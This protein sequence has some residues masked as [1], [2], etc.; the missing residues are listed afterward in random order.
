VAKKKGG[1]PPAY[2]AAGV[3]VMVLL[4]FNG[5]NYF[6][7]GGQTSS[8]RTSSASQTSTQSTSQTPTSTTTTSTASTV[9]GY[10]P[11]PTGRRLGFWVADDDVYSGSSVFGNAQGTV[12]TPQQFFHAYFGTSPYP[13]TMVWTGGLQSSA[14]LAVAPAQES[15]WLSNLLSICDNYPNIEVWMIAFINLSGNSIEGAHFAPPAPWTNAGISFARSGTLTSFTIT[16]AA[17]LAPSTAY[18]LQLLD[19]A[20]VNLIANIATFT[21]DS[22]GAWSGTAALPN[23]T[24][25]QANAGGVVAVQGT[26]VGEGIGWTQDQTSDFTAYMQA[27]RGHRSFLG[28]LFEPEYFGNTPAI[29]AVFQGIVNGAGY[30][31][32]GGTD[33]PSTGSVVMDYSEYPYL[34]GTLDTGSAAAGVLG[35]HYGETGSSSGTSPI[36]TQAVVTNIV[37]NSMTAP[38][39]IFNMFNDVNN[40]ATAA[41]AFSNLDSSCTPPPNL[42]DWYLYMSPTVRGWI[43]SDPHYASYLQSG[44][45]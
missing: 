1:L 45:T 35:V 37:D 41:P 15:Q 5:Q 32:L 11:L 43:Y 23:T 16:S 3:L 9:T 28:V 31:V 19:Q 40:P 18:T 42:C 12:P 8:S 2:V 17:G 6:G 39:T 29:Q 14:S 10:P 27:I 33:S 4:A 7:G 30:Y 38:I 24:A 22:T 44:A 26:R 20:G 25:Q 36:W 21:T 13:A 34:S